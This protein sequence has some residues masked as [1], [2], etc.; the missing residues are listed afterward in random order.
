MV[1]ENIENG[2]GPLRHV[3]V[4][5]GER[6]GI[7]VKDEFVE[8]VEEALGKENVRVRVLEGVGHEVAVERAGEILSIVREALGR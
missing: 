5:L 4:V 7:I 6:D 8:D 1:K 3:W 2:V